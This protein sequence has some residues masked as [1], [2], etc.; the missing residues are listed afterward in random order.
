MKGQFDKVA[1]ATKVADG[2]QRLPKDSKL[3]QIDG[4]VHSFFGRYGPQSGDGVP[5][6]SRTDAEREIVNAIVSFLGRL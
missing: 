2:L 3:V 1:D 5:A 4:G 6:V